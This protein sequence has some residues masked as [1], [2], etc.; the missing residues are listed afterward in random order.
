VT[1]DLADLVGLIAAEVGARRGDG[2]QRHEIDIASDLMTEIGM[3]A[4]TTQL[5]RLTLMLHARHKPE[6]ITP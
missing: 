5:N 6:E 4:L 3:P 2:D 1:G